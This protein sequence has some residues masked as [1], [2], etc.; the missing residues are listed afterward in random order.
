MAEPIEVGQARAPRHRFL[1]SIMRASYRP[2]RAPR[3]RPTRIGRI[4]LIREPSNSGQSEY[5][6]R[7]SLTRIEARR[8]VG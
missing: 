7:Y 3:C 5:T 2:A 6:L 4:H 8:F 1:G